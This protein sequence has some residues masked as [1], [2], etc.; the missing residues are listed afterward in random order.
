MRPPRCRTAHSAHR[1]PCGP[2]RANVPGHSTLSGP[3]GFPWSPAAFPW[4]GHAEGTLGSAW[5]ARH[6]AADDEVS[7]ADWGLCVER[8]TRIEIALC[9]WESPA[10]KG[11]SGADQLQRARQAAP[12]STCSIWTV[13]RDPHLAQRHGLQRATGPATMLSIQAPCTPR[14]DGDPYRESTWRRLS[15]PGRSR[16]GAWPRSSPPLCVPH[17]PPSYAPVPP[18]AP[19]LPGAP[20]SVPE[21]SASLPARR[22]PAPPGWRSRPAE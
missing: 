15:R 11:P 6:E 16:H 20:R 1:D 8:V 18:G 17:R 2:G 14:S 4:F 19:R 9:S 10:D 5:W 13:A 12:I 22:P 7:G 21:R 3:H